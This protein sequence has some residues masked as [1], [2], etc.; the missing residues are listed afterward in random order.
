MGSIPGLAEWV[1]ESTVATAVNPAAAR[2]QSLAQEFPHTKGLAIEIGEEK[3]KSCHIEG[4]HRE[5]E[6]RSYGRWGDG[7]L[8]SAQHGAFYDSKA[9]TW[10]SCARRRVCPASYREEAIEGEMPTYIKVTVVW[11]YMEATLY[12]K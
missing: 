1:K 10:Q 4:D 8:G 9:T 2:I 12:C 11:Q 6:F 5:N 3:K 7:K